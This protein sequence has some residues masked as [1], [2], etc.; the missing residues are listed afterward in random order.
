MRKLIVICLTLLSVHLWAAQIKSVNGKK[1][2]IDLQSDSYKVGDILKISNQDGNTVGLT[3]IIKLKGHLA[4]G[5]LKGKAEE[6]FVATLRPHKSKKK[7]SVESVATVYSGSNQSFIGVLFGYNSANMDAKLPTSGA[8]VSLS[9]NGMSLKGLFDIALF[10]ALPMISLRGLAG[11]EQLQVEGSTN[12]ECAGTCEV[13]ITYLA[14]DIWGR[15]LIHLNNGFTPWGGAGFDMLMPLSKDA[16]V[17]KKSSIT[18]TYLFS[19]GG[20]FDWALSNSSYLPFQI[21]YNFYPATDSV[22]T[23]SFTFRGGYAMSY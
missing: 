3:K 18:T 10:S 12:S 9:G 16:S 2:T 21:E 7:K 17:I 23:S 22:K 14:A 19:I 11:F 8:T 6:G 15:Y 5:L 20:G 13:K 4:E 1:V